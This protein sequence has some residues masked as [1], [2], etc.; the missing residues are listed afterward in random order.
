MLT[1]NARTPSDITS[2]TN[3]FE[4]GGVTSGKDALSFLL[5]TTHPE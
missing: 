5:H 1:T 2:A 4:G 3:F